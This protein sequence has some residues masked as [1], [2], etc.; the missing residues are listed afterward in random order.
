MPKAWTSEFEAQ[1]IRA[2]DYRQFLGLFFNQSNTSPKKMT[3]QQFSQKAGFSSKSFVADIIAGRK[4]ITPL[5]IEKVTQG[6]SLN[7]TWTE[8]FKALVAKD[9]PLF[10]TDRKTSKD[11]LKILEQLRNRIGKKGL[12]LDA[13]NKCSLLENSNFPTIYASLGHPETGASLSEIALRAK[14]PKE[15]ILSLLEKLLQRGW[16]VHN[17]SLQRYYPQAEFIDFVQM[18][19]DEN[20]ISD[21][22]RSIQ[23]VKSRFPKLSHQQSC[24][25]MTQTFTI[26][27]SKLPELNHRLKEVLLEF[28]NHAEN[29][30]GDTVAELLISFSHND[31]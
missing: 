3:F 17:P 10:W 22:L 11:Y 21:Y 27:K 26:E 16:V 23:K 8:Y 13:T 15:E 9:E 20:F 1:A 2:P 28:C 31:N 18:G 6:L 25:F 5:S 14:V 19:A 12:T 4:R 30:E 24:T 7:K 29:T